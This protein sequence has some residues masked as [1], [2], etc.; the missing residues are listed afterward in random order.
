MSI[1]QVH[2]NFDTNDIVLRAQIADVVFVM[3]P[4]IFVVLSK[5]IES[6][7]RTPQKLRAVIIFSI[8]LCRTGDL[9]FFLLFVESP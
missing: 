5:I 9:R 6:D 2:D 1:L 8:F 3:T 4:R 7:A